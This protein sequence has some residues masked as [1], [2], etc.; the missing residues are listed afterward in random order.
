[1]EVATGVPAIDIRCSEIAVKDLV[2]IQTTPLS[3]PLKQM[4]EQLQV[5]KNPPKCVGPLSLATAQAHEA[6]I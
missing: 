3:H 4:L 6:T 5:E 1:M 2:K